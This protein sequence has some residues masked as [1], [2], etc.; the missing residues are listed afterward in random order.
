MIVAG[1]IGLGVMMF[2]PFLVKSRED[3]RSLACARYLKRLGDGVLQYPTWHGTF[4][5]GRGFPDWS[6]NGN[7]RNAYTSYGAV[8]SA[9]KTQFLSAFTLILPYV[10]REDVASLLCPEEPRKQMTVGGGSVPINANIPAVIAA[11]K[12]FICPADA[13]TSPGAVSE[14]NYRFNFGGSTPYGGAR[15]TQ[16]QTDID[17]TVTDPLTGRTYSSRGNGAFTIG[18]GLAPRHF[19]DGLG[20]TAFLSER[21]KGSGINTANQMPT[22]AEIMTIDDR[23]DGMLLPE[24]IYSRCQKSAPTVSPFNFNSAGRWLVGTDWSNGWLFA[25]YDCTQYNHLAP[26][27]WQ[28]LDCGG[29]SS[30][31]DTPGEHA[32]I[33]ARSQHPG[34]VN[35]FF[36]D[37]HIAQISNDIDLSVWRAMGA[38]DD[39]KQNRHTSWSY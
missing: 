34:F 39:Q 16:A 29:F 10:G 1:I 7:P 9:H 18:K 4:P 24:E 20:K 2:L 5:R 8:N 25:G 12:F 11:G 31:P 35:V 37:G 26:P 14:T 19:P 27:N 36:G 38:R 21:T 6:A 32:I 3:L 17:S 15:A 13:N 23:F 33:A 28:H 30:I 22:L